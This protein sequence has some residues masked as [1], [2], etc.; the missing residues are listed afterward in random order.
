MRLE[1][2][3]RDAA[4]CRARLSR[5][6]YLQ[7]AGFKSGLELE[8]IY[9]DYR[10]LFEPE[11][12][13]ELRDL[14]LEAPLDE[15]YRRFLL[16]FAA[17]GFLEQSVRERTEAIALAEAVTSFSVEALG[18]DLTYRGA[19]VAWSNE[20]DAA[21]RHEINA[22]W[23][24]EV[25]RLNPERVERHQRTL[26]LV[27]ELGLGSYAELWDQLRGLNL[28]VLNEQMAGLLA[29]TAD[30][31]RDLLRDLLAEHEL[32]PA[33]AWRA[34]LAHALRGSRFDDDFP[35][36]RLLGTLVQTL[37]PLGFELEEQHNITLDLESRPAKSAR[38][39]CATLDVPN[40][41][42]L[43]LRPTGGHQDYQ[44]LLHEAGHVEHY[45]NV[46]RTLGFAYR[47]LGDSSLTEGYAFLF[48]YLPTDPLWLRRMLDPAAPDEYRRFALF[49]KL[50]LVRRYAVKLLYEQELWGSEE[51]EPLADRYAELFTHHLLVQYW[52]EEYLS[53]LDPAF[54]SAQYLRAWMFEAQLRD[55]LRREFDEEWFRMP[56]AGRF[57]RDLWREGQKYTA[58]ELVRFMGFER[59]EPTLL[60]RDIQ[61][62]LAQ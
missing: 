28:A 39:F 48:H 20:P 6:Y 50:Q 15:K 47:W 18:R 53:D 23:R 54:Y 55:F 38:A 45:A 40:D 58:D 57:L 13:H 35:A 2:F 11:T 37:R 5:E 22:L 27:G 33:E 29:S 30:L 51:P 9:A 56:K 1:D 52:P 41:V 24:Q 62:V 46:D 21:V 4:A 17:A 16:D 25:D 34:D 36:K 59:L 26:E 31:Y 3:E 60:L 7:R 10:W 61:E 14:Q 19:P 12:F 43:V 32:S 42:R 49:E 44:S 8:P